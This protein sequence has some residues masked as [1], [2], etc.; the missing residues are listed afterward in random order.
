MSIK[1]LTYIKHQNLNPPKK[2]KLSENIRLYKPPYNSSWFETGNE[3]KVSLDIYIKKLFFISKKHLSSN[4]HPDTI[5]GIIVPHDGIK[6]SGICSAS[7][8]YQLLGR[9]QSSHSIKRIIL[10]CTN[11]STSNSFVSTSYSHIES[12]IGHHPLKIDIPSIEKLKPYLQIDDNLFNTEHAFYNQLPFI[13]EIIRNDTSHSSTS[14]SSTSPSSTPPLILPILISNKLDL[15]TKRNCDCIRVILTYLNELMKSNNTVLICTSDFSHVNGEYQYKINSYISQN[16]RKQDNSI[17]QFIY[18][19]LNGIRTPSKKIDDI[20]FIQN[21]PSCGTMAM[22]FTAKL[23]NIYSGVS[24]YSSSSSSDSSCDI[25]ASTIMKSTQNKKILYPRITSYYT[26][27]HNTNIKNLNSLSDFNISNITTTLNLTDNRQSSISYVGLIFTTQYSIDFKKGRK[28]ENLFSEYEKIALLEFVK[29]Q[30]YNQ[31]CSNSGSGS[32]S[33]SYTNSINIPNTLIAP[34]NSQVYNKNLGAFISVYKEGKLRAN[35]GTIES[36]NDE[37]TIESNLKRFAIKLGSNC[38]SKY[39]YIEFPALEASEFNKLTF[40]ITFLYSTKAISINDY[41]GNKFVFGNDCL[42][43]AT[44]KTNKTAKYSLSNIEINNDSN[45]NI[46]SF[47]N[48]NSDSDN[49]IYK[50]IM[51]DSLCNDDDKMLKNYN[52]TDINLYYNECLII[53]NK[54]I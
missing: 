26:S 13:E 14:H 45:R 1:L 6:S 4:V 35:I 42:V 16:I 52:M 21:A 7:A 38:K 50:S 17:L 5:K 30:L 2:L 48:S 28:I 29:Q 9:T 8:Y 12:Y 20:L 33:G 31:F 39:R 51:L 22:Y 53:S 44:C 47:S 27:N 41:F 32:G 24:D 49:S 10:L 36:N 23:L 19:E 46:N 3:K 18:D 43:L 34:I 11:H 25:M 15:S 40:N 54:N 37:F